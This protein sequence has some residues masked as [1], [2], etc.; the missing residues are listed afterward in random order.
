MLLNFTVENC[1]SFKSEQEFT[2]LRTGGEESDY[3]VDSI[4]F[5]GGRRWVATRKGEPVAQNYIRP[6]FKQRY[7]P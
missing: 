5:Q 2:M 4:I 3:Q 7:S 6:Q 1:L